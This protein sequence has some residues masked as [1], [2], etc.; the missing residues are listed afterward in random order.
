MKMPFRLI[1]SRETFQRDMD[2][3][4]IGLIC[5]CVVVYLDDI[6]IFSKDRKDHITHLRRIFNRCRRYGIS[7]NPKKYVFSVDEGRLLRFIVSKEGMMIDLERTESISKIPPPHNKKSMQSFLVN[8]NFVRI[9]V[10]SFV[11]TIKPLQDMI[12]N[13]V[14]LKLGPKENAFKKKIKS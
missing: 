13:N 4:L 10:P 5:D 7:L 1:N 14:D 12:K 9:F 6:K 8:I 11:E 3:A 2:I